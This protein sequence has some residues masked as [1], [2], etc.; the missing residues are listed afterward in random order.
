[1]KIN[2]MPYFSIYELDKLVSNFGSVKA[3][4]NALDEFRTKANSRY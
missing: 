1:M 4:R 3:T 2:G